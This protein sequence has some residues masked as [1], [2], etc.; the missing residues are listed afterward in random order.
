VRHPAPRPAPIRG[1]AV[2]GCEGFSKNRADGERSD[3]LHGAILRQ[4]LQT[5]ARA[6]AVHR[7]IGCGRIGA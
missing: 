3:G 2:K 7:A 4:S 1:E 5:L 6:P